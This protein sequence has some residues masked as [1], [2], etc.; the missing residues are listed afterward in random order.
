MNDKIAQAHNYVTDVPMIISMN[1]FEYDIKQANIN[2]LFALNLISEDEYNNLSLLPKQQREVIIGKKLQANSKLGD[3]LDCGITQAKSE[4]INCNKIDS[5][6]VV[7]VANDA[8]YIVA[9]YPLGNTSFK[10]SDNSN[11][12]VTFVLKNRFTS[13]IKLGFVLVFFA[14]KENDD[15]VVDIKGI[16]DKMLHLHSNLLTFICTILFYLERSNKAMA[17]SEYSKFYSDYVNLNLDINYYR[18]FNASSCF[19]IKGSEFGVLSFK[20]DMRLLDINYN[21]YLLRNMYSFILGL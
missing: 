6:Q 20:D 3:F 1:I 7:R 15:F 11:H 18:E 13:Y 10:I 19:R 12:R 4:L 9:N 21:L 17:L 14:I 2:V 8:M 5:N 16:N